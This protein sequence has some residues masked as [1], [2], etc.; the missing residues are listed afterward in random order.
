MKYFGKLHFSP[1]SED[2]KNQSIRLY[3]RNV[4]A[5]KK[6]YAQL[7]RKQGIDVKSNFSIFRM[8]CFAQYFWSK[9]YYYTSRPSANVTD[10][11]CSFMDFHA[12]CSF[13]KKKKII[14]SSIRS[15]ILTDYG[16]MEDCWFWNV[17]RSKK[18]L[19]LSFPSSEWH[20]Y[21]TFKPFSDIKMY[22]GT[23]RVGKMTHY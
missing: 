23:Q 16:T 5:G 3:M 14:H 20:A 11:T 19:S 21:E 8:I 18:I 13:Y 12:H 7:T 15:A 22:G 9:M 6:G 10:M 1:K 4:P 17:L 2:Q